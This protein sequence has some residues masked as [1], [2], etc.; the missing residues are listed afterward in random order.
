M[1]DNSIPADSTD[2]TDALPAVPADET[3]PFG[4][5]QSSPST[6]G[7]YDELRSELD[8]SVMD[9]SVVEREQPPYVAGTIDVSVF[10]KALASF[11]LEQSDFLRHQRTQDNDEY[12]RMLV[13]YSL[14]Q[15][16]YIRAMSVV[17]HQLGVI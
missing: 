1:T 12:L 10:L 17:L 9:Q 16:D 8:R 13:R 15:D 7:L 11:N 14:A 2:R 3:F 6:A 5:H 4:A